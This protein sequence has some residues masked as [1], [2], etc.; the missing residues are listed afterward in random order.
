MHL[1]LGRVAEFAA[2]G[3]LQPVGDGMRFG[4]R[5]RPVEFEVERQCEVLTHPLH[6]DVVDGDTLAQRHEQHTVM[7]G[8]VGRRDRRRLDG[9]LGVGQDRPRGRHRFLPHFRELLEAE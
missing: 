6:G 4:Q 2:N 7:H 8:L 3:G 9:H 1:D 5:Q